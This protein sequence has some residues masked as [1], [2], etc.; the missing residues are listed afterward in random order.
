MA[1]V[2]IVVGDSYRYNGRAGW[3]GPGKYE[4]QMA[5]AH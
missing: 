4:P 2:S 1:G 3:E 5:T